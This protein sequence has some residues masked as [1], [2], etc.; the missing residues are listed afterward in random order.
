[1]CSLFI[2]V[3]DCGELGNPAGGSVS[4]AAGTTFGSTAEY[5][6]NIGFLLIG[7]LERTCQ[8]DGQWSGMEPTCVPSGWGGK[9][10]HV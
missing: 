1:M 2:T 10:H 5:N 9:K 7:N 6:C 8:S 3:V 4:I